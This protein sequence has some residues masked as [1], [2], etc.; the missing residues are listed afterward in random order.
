VVQPGWV[1]A[2]AAYQDPGGIATGPISRFDEGDP[3]PQATNGAAG[4]PRH[5]GFLAYAFG[6]NTVV[7]RSAFERAGG[8]SE[9]FRTGEDVDLSW[10]IQC[11]GEELS[12][13]SGA[14]VSVRV[15]SRASG[16][17]GQ[18]LSYGRGDVQLYERYRPQGCPRPSVLPTMK[19]Y[20][21]LVA[22]LP[23]LF[24]P[25]HRLAWL[26]Q[27]G[28]RTGRIIGSFERRVFYP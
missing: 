18:Y 12:F 9:S 27:L 22:R 14:G 10:R 19:S 16:V 6:T 1:A 11:S 7:N 5:M 21:G 4:P 28:R 8:F 24:D 26:H 3:A 13:L 20:A 25:R 17:F 15:R 2:V 23:L